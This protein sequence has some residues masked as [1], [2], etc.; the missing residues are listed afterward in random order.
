MQAIS[1]LTPYFLVTVAF[2]FIYLFIPNSRVRVVPSL[3]GVV[4]GGFA[5]QTAGLVFAVFIASS[6][7]Y[8]AIYSSL[9]LSLIHI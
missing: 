2:T 5:W 1:R 9:A 6:N 4:A 7:K 8:A 3:I